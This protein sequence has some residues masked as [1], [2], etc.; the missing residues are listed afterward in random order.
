ME[1]MNITFG[2]KKLKKAAED[3]N[4]HYLWMEILVV[5]IEEIVDYHK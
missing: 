4:H 5:E 1:E 2:D 3:G